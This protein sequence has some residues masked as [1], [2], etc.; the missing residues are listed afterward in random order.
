M[1]IAPADA[2]AGPAAVYN[3]EEESVTWSS[4]NRNGILVEGGAENSTGTSGYRVS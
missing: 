4:G 3:N 1:P 2:R